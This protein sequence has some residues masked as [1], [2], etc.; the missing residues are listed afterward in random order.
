VTTVL[1]MAALYLAALLLVQ[2]TCGRLAVSPELSRT[3]CHIGC[4][5]TAAAMPLLATRQQ[6]IALALF[7]A[8]L[9]AVSQWRRW[10]PCIHGVAR[11]SVGEICFPLACAASALLAPSTLAY[12]YSVLVLAL[13][14]PMANLIGRRL[15]GSPLPLG[16]SCTT[17]AGSAAFALTT[18]LVGAI[19]CPLVAPSAGRAILL[20]GGVTLAATAAEARCG[21]GLDNLVLPPL[22]AVLSAVL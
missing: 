19:L 17:A 11:R 10:L 2:H 3:L 21:R 9:M 22:V 20:M 6:L 12:T 4:G 18:L 16:R 8:A 13:A 1:A 5:V 14:D 7:M 15:G